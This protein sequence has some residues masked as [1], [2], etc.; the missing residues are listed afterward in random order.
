MAI[1]LAP[2][3]VLVLRSSGCA[4]GAGSQSSG[5]PHEAVWVSTA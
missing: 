2:A 5:P 3:V 4:L 1:M